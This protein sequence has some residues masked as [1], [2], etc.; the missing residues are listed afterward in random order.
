MSLNLTTASNHKVKRTL[1]NPRCQIKKLI[2]RTRPTCQKSL[3]TNNWLKLG[4][5]PRTVSVWCPEALCIL[6]LS[7]S[8]QTHHVFSVVSWNTDISSRLACLSSA[9]ILH[10]SSCF[11]FHVSLSALSSFCRLS[12]CKD[13]T[14]KQSSIMDLETTQMEMFEPCSRYKCQSDV[15]WQWFLTFSA[16]M[17][18][19]LLSVKAAT[20]FWLSISSLFPTVQ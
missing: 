6:W 10:K 2:S 15:S 11:D 19:V 17:C 5:E 16:S 8:S 1:T 18:F 20:V 4:N 3:W 9:E 14:S 13:T 12:N 7:P